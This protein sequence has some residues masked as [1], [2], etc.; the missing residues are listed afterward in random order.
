VNL[1]RTVLRDAWARTLITDLIGAG[2]VF[3]ALA[4]S[5]SDPNNGRPRSTLAP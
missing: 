2:Q 5:T 4:S 3:N 1:D